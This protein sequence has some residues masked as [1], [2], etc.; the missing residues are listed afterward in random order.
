MRQLA[1]QCCSACSVLPVYGLPSF[2]V[3][4]GAQLSADQGLKLTAKEMSNCNWAPKTP[5]RNV[6][7]QAF[8]AGAKFTSF[9]GPISCPRGCRRTKALVNI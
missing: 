6:R 8:F 7:I 1:A 5:G 4:T 9:V 2:P 3:F